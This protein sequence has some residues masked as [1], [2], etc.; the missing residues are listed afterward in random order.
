MLGAG[1]GDDLLDP[2]STLCFP[3]SSL[4]WEEGISMDR[5]PPHSLSL[6]QEEKKSMP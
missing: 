2:M 4:V 3:F 5:L 6:F 1:L